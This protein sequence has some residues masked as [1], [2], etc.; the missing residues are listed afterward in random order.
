[1]SACVRRSLA[2]LSAP[3][4][5]CLLMAPLQASPTGSKATLDVAAT[6]IC[7]PVAVGNFGNRVHV[8]CST[9]VSGILYFAQSTGDANNVARTLA[10]LSTAMASGRDLRIYYDAADTSGTAIGCQAGD[11]RLIQTAELL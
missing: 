2:S 4:L 1:M 9:A 5:F 7:T 8:R 11:C 6:T 10:L 3:A